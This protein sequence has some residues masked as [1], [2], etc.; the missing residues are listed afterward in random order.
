LR[1]HALRALWLRG[2]GEVASLRGATVREVAARGKHLLVALGDGPAPYVLH[3]HL[4]MRGRVDAYRPDEPW[5][6][7]VHQAGVAW[8]AAGR[9]W[10]VFRAPVVELLRG[11]ELALHP[12][13]SRL[14]PDLLAPDVDTGRI[15]ARARRR[16]ARP[17][18]EL[19]LDQT[20][21][22]GIGNVY[23]SE[24]LFRAGVHPETPARELADATL[25]A[26]YADARALLAANLGPWHRTTVRR[27]TPERP[28]R[29]GEPRL[30]VYGRPGRP[31]RR[32][33]ARV[34]VARVGDRARPTFWCPRCQ[35]ARGGASAGA[36]A[37]VTT[38]PRSSSG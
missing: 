8:E 23:K 19:L 28:L 5:R 26:L 36:R 35:P 34:A 37:P 17:V 29:R 30:F 3:L 6:R 12:T 7:P 16:D 25:A 20:V 18:A 11:V 21:A 9:H 38:I 13:L 15:L 31:C 2:R 32:C 33:Q 10:V 22:C 4:G 14:G 1:G 27:V 24:L